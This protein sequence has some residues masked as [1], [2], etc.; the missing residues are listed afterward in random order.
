VK[1]NAMRKLA[2]FYTRFRA[3]PGI[4][5]YAIA[6]AVAVLLMLAWPKSAGAETRVARQGLDEVRIFDTACVSAETLIRIPE[7]ERERFGKAQ[8]MFGGQRFFGCW[9]PL[10]GDA[11]ILWEDG[12]QGIVPKGDLKPAPEA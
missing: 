9:R 4:V 3:M 12:D 10:G 7:A 11:F 5:Q 2:R 8:G 1:E 6:L